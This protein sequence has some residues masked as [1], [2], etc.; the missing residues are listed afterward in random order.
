M[1][2]AA[3]VTGYDG[4]QTMCDYLRTVRKEGA[5]GKALDYKTVNIEVT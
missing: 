1:R 3:A 2:L 4:P 5:H